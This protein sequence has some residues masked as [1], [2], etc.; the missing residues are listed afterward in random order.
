MDEV[1]TA[2]LNAVQ[3]NPR[4]TLAGLAALTKA[5]LS[6]C[7]R[8]LRRLEDA[9]YIAGYRAIIDPER[10][11]L[12][13]HALVFVALAPGPVDRFEEFEQAASLLPEVIEV[14]R[15]SGRPEYVLRVMTS[16]SAGFNILYDFQL[17]DLP[18]VASLRSEL[19]LGVPV[20]ARAI[21]IP[22][23]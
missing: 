7:H 8:R 16:D 23:P 5:T 10:V 4:I 1:D 21:A 17:S 9:G 11:G 19:I 14:L 3:S 2:I 15:L 6:T 13:F 22:S 12:T 20:P 18:R